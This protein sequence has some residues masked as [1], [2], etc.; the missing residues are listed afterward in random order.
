MKKVFLRL[1]EP[2]RFLIIGVVN[3]IFGYSLFA[4]MLWTL[5]P[6]ISGLAMSDMSI[7]RLAGNHFYSVI[8]W[9]NWFLSVPF[10]TYM[11]RRFV[12]KKFGSYPRQVLNAYGV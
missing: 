5:T 3:T 11:M 12:F 7:L 4:L 8:Q 6:S 1:E 2:L 10:S 9:M